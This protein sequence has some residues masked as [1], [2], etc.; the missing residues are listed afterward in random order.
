MNEN[1]EI[2]DLKR[3][4]MMI[5]VGLICVVILLLSIALIATAA[6][7]VPVKGMVTMI[8]L[9]ATACIP[10]KLM[11]PILVKLEKQYAGR[12]AVVFFDVWKDQAP[13]KRFGIRTIPTQIF[14]DKDGKEVYRH[15]GFL[16]EEEI[17][18]RFK[19]MGVK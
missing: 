12:A 1:K 10:C 2:M 17:I 11:A 8:D 9:G 16:S 4:A 14:F 18:S 13:A 5:S 15:E 3:K 7:D 6:A 19:D